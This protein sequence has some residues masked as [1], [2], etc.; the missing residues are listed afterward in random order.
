MALGNIKLK[1]IGIA[2]FIF[3]LT[4]LL[5][6]KL[7][8]MRNYS[9]LLVVFMLAFSACQL[10]STDDPT[11]DDSA[12]INLVGNWNR[13]SVLVNDVFPSKL[14]VRIETE[15]NYGAYIFNSDLKTGVLTL[16]GSD[17]GITWKYTS[18]TKTLFINEIDWDN[19]NY[20]VKEIS[21][22]KLMLTGYKDTGGGNQN[23]RII[24]LSR[25]K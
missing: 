21:K 12:S 23:E 14:K 6:Q 19:T 8:C 9:K 16:S 4:A 17:F 11:P 20:A 25:R 7:I 10:D 18:S 2:Y 15:V 22:D 1:R 13:D 5:L 3:K 24:Y